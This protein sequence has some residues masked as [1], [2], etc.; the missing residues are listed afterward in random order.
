[1][2]PVQLEFEFDLDDGTVASITRT[3]A[4]S[5]IAGRLIRSHNLSLAERFAL[6]EICCRATLSTDEESD[7]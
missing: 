7:R 3:A 2:N 6:L 4:P 1:M 5:Q